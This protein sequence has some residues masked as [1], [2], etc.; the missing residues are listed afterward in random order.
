MS[1]N[2][3]VISGTTPKSWSEAS[4]LDQRFID[5]Q[6]DLDK[7][8]NTNNLKPA[9]R[10]ISEGYNNRTI[11]DITTKQIEESPRSKLLEI[12]LQGQQLRSDI[13]T[14]KSSISAKVSALE[15]YRDAISDYLKSAYADQFAG[16][17]N[18]TMRKA[19]IASLFEE[20]NARIQQLYRFIDY[21]DERIK[22]IDQEKWAVKS[23]IDAMNINEAMGGEV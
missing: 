16:L 15:Q 6:E 20:A 14:E 5:F 12:L 11:R 22:D 7:R 9:M 2:E 13:V 8:F 19:A 4:K 1:Y 21:C 17:K 23:I 10:K 3:D 18:E